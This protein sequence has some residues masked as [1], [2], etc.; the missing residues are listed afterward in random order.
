[1]PSIIAP[2]WAAQIVTNATATTSASSQSAVIRIPQMETYLFIL[3]VTTLTGTGTTL[4]VSLAISPAS[5][6]NSAALTTSV[7]HQIGK[8]TQVT[9]A[10]GA[11]GLRLQPTMGRGEAASTFTAG[12]SD[13]VIIPA[14]TA[15]AANVPLTPDIRFYWATSAQTTYTFSI[16]AYGYAKADASY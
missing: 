7:W 11:W 6:I 8:F 2:V 10:T 9:T 16:Y 3:D 1:M 4:D 14:G 12:A 5:T 15:V 13:S